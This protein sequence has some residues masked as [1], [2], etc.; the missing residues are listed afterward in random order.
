MKIP[1]TTPPF[2]PEDQ[3]SRQKAVLIKKKKQLKAGT[4]YLS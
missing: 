3:A 4:E 1:Q 2:S